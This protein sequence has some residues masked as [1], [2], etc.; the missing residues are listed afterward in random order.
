MEWDCKDKLALR[1]I[2]YYAQQEH[3]ERHI[4]HTQAVA[5]YTRLIAA[6]ENLGEQTVNLMEM[7]AWLHDIGCPVAILKHGNSLPEYQQKEGKIITTEWLRDVHC[8]TPDEKQW[9]ADVVGTHHQFHAA[10]ELR[11]EPLFE[12]DLIVNLLEG[13]YERGKARHLYDKLTVTDAGR[14]LFTTIF[15]KE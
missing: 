14:K 7:A 3:A 10:Q 6:G 5:S 13:Y 11:F 1:V 4:L 8:L 2:A 9:L 15:F 12:A